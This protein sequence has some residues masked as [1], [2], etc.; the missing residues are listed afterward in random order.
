MII[1]DISYIILLKLQ[2]NIYNL[3]TEKGDFDETKKRANLL[4]RYHKKSS[5]LI[6][7]AECSTRSD[8]YD[9]FVLTNR[10][11]LKTQLCLC[12]LAVQK[13]LRSYKTVYNVHP[14]TK[15]LTCVTL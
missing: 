4:L 15:I 6:A 9:D 11:Y 3:P 8:E 7:T 14:V 13:V 10:D 1:Y 2:F 5:E 12:E